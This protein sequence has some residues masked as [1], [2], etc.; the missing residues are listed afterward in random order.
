MKINCFE[1]IQAWQKA[2]D[3]AV[4]IATAKW[5]CKMIGFHQFR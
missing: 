4:F 5:F 1:D 3:L 2:R